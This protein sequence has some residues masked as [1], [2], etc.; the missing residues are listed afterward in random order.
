MKTKLIWISV[1]LVSAGCNLEEINENPNV[2]VEVPLSTLLPPAQKGSADAYGGRIF[3]YTGIFA[4][5]LAGVDGQEL[6]FENYQPDEQ[7][8]GNVWSDLYVG[9]MVNLKIILDQGA[10]SESPHYTGVARVMMAQS[11]GI[12]SDL[13]GDVPY[14][15]ALQ[16]PAFPNPEYDSQEAIYA[17]IQSLLDQG[18]VE[19]GLPESTFSPGPDDIFFQGNLQAWIG[20]ANLLKARYY[21]RT[22]KR[23]SSAA[24]DALN[25]LSGAMT[26][27][28][29]DLQYNYLGSGTDINP[30]S[31]FYQIT[32]HA[33]IDALFIDLLETRADPRLPHIFGSIPFSGGGKRPSDFFASENAPIKL[34]SYLE[35]LFISAEAKYRT[36][37]Q[38][39]AQNDLNEAVSLSMNQVSASAIS[40]EVIGI[41]LDTQTQLSGNFEA[42][43]Q[44]ILTEKYIALFTSPEPWADWRRT[45]YPV[46]LP[47]AVGSTAAN[48]NG[49][50]PR[51]LI[52][53][54]SE[55]LRNTNF[56]QPAPNMQTRF[57]WDLN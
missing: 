44:T 36:G 5:Q 55:R 24:T 48:P 53:P 45:G 2:P 25:A 38:S 35:R 37:D 31:S 47:N 9:S 50:I 3:R 26:S 8:V 21:L 27:S 16:G 46:L 17:E 15:Q 32:P 10:E 1:C 14:S 30:I 52:Y 20:A 51:R 29:N 41:H 40:S 49:E 4:Q 57:W 22:T 11:L 28:A 23:S 6:L 43:L 42:D 7:F 12:L 18:I 34:G 19:L 33:F 13:W 54:Q 56:P 39:G